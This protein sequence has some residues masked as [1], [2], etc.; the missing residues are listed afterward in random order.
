M[1]NIKI[2][3]VDLSLQFKSLRSEILSRVTN[4]L[5]SGDYILGR[6]VKEFEDTFAKYCETKFAIGV[7]NGTD[8]LSICMKALGIGNGDEVITAPNSFAI[9][10]L[11]F[12]SDFN[13][14]CPI[15]SASILL[16]QCLLNSFAA[17]VF[18]EPI[19][20]VMPSIIF[21]SIIDIYLQFKKL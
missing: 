15:S 3:F 5:E 21:K 13:S 8:A 2:K 6:E 18:P 12:L 4:V 14:L 7:G 11:I 16:Y 9:L 10:V 19:E 1:V 17:V 20:P